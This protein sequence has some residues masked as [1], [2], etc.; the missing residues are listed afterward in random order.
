MR[1]IVVYEHVSLADYYSTHVM[2]EFRV[3]VFVTF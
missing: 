3:T 2:W 1:S